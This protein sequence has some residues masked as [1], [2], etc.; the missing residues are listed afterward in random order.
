[1]KT[2]IFLAITVYVLFAV[3]D[4]DAR[5]RTRCRLKCFGRG[6]GAYFAAERGPFCLCKCYRCAN[7]SITKIGVI[8]TVEQSSM[9]HQQIDNFAEEQAQFIQ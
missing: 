9:F 7:E 5:C 2:A 1:M 8:Q 3:Q 4:A 6:C